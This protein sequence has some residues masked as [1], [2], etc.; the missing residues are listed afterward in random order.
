MASDP[1]KV[2]SMIYDHMMHR[3]SYNEW[4]KYIIDI[5]T[6][7]KNDA[8][9][10]LEIACG[11]GKLD[12][13]LEKSFNDIVLLDISKSM[14]DCIPSSKKRVCANMTRQPFKSNF[15]F[16][17][18]TFD[19]INYITDEEE[20]VKYMGE[21]RNILSD[22]G[23]FTFDASL[24][25]NSIKNVKRLNRVN[26]FRG[27]EYKQVSKYEKDIRLHMNSFRMKL[28]NG[29]IIEEVHT[30][31][32][33]DFEFYFDAAERAGLHVLDCFEA[34]TFEDANEE[35]ERIQFIMKKL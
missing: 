20:I 15:D 9:K 27:M 17:Y 22:D 4:A 14:L 8:E 34:F 19:S 12:K 16:I 5:K 2:V 13:Y 33:Y 23:I 24:E 29:E 10:F 1:Y 18:S 28:A 25:T 26:K 21:I 3:L 6:F 30:Q 31:K 35:S 7:Y 11:T 32:I